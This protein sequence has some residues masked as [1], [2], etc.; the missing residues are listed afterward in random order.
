MTILNDLEER[1][2]RSSTKSPRQWIENNLWIKT[3]DRRVILLRFNDIQEEY[4]ANK[5][6]WDII[7]KYRQGGISTLVLAE[8]FEDTARNE[9]TTSVVVAHDRD[10]T[11][12]LFNIVKMYFDRLPLD[13]K[14]RLCANPEKPQYKNRRELY[15]DKI[16]S[17][18]VVGTAG[19]I[20]FGRGQT[21]NNLHCSEVAF[22]PRPED[23]M[24][25]LL[26]AVPSGGRVRLE[27]TP[28]GFNYFYNEC[29]DAQMGEGVYNFHFFPWWV[30]KDYTEDLDSGED[31]Q[32][33]SS[34]TEEEQ[35]LIDRKDLTLGQIKWRRLKKKTL[36]KKFPQEYPEDDISCFLG[37]GNCV[38]DTELLADYLHGCRNPI[39]TEENGC[40]KVWKE[41][42]K[43]K[44]YAIGADVAEGL[45]HGDFSTCY[46]IDE[47]TAED[48]A[49]MKGHWPPEV[50]AKKLAELGHYYAKHYPRGQLPPVI[51]VERNNHGHSVLN[52]L[53]N[54]EKYESIY[55]HEDYDPRTRQKRKRLGWPTD[56][57]TKPIMIDDLD[58]ILRAGVPVNSK[59][60]VGEA[61]T[62]IRKRDGA[63]EAEEGCHDD[64]VVA[65][66]IAV[67]MRKK[68]RPAAR[69]LGSKPKGW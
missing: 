4:W 45:E 42:E 30:Q 53:V 15:F 32:I 1:L 36:K 20:E 6:D 28:N 65:R 8:F 25:G 44:K 22:W 24:A 43:G 61:M 2:L 17:W 38:F 60:F 47:E 7:L 41:P 27:S 56:A 21:I 57:V 10:S 34:L 48:V 29:Q 40:L 11:E 23:L 69:A 14:A 33:Q 19:N 16:N 31:A 39:R 55:R 12:K 52:T 9:N 54:T 66:A 51:G 59:D 5:T 26:E 37:S 63:M 3:K 13:E 62:F 50:F 49:Q 68:Y 58:A 18:F 67:Q 35:K 64:L 46:V